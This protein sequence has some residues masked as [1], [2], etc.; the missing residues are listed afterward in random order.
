MDTTVN[1][2]PSPVRCR[3]VVVAG[4]LTGPARSLY[5]RVRGRD[6]PAGPSGQLVAA[7]VERVAMR[8]SGMLPGWRTVG[9]TR[10]W[11][12]V[13]LLST[14]CLAAAAPA[15]AAPFVYVANG[16]A[17]SVSE[18]D[19]AGG[20]LVPLPATVV[21][22]PS[23]PDLVAVAPDG[24]SV[25]VT[26]TENSTVLQFDVAANGTLTL[27]T[28]PTVQTGRVPAGI[29]VTSDGKGVYVSDFSDNRVSQYDI[30]PGGALTPTIPATV[31]TGSEPEGVA[32]SPDGKSVYVANFN[33][34]TVSQY[35]VGAGEALTP[36]TPKTVPAGNGPVGI[37]V[38]P[39]GK[40]AYVTNS[41]GNTVSQYDIGADGVLAPKTPAMVAAGNIP[42]GI[43]VSP[44][45]QSVY[46]AD[47]LDGLIAEYAVSAGG[48]VLKTPATIAAGKQPFGVVVSPDGKSVYATASLASSVFQFS[49]GSGLGTLTAK[50]PA[51]VAAGSFP[52]GIAVGPA[53]VVFRCAGVISACTVRIVRFPP[54]GVTDAVTINATSVRAA[55]LGILVERIVGKRR[56]RVGRVPFGLRHPGR[57]RIRWNLRVNGHKLAQ[58]RYVITLRMFDVHM[59]LIALARPIEITIR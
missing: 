58:G 57:L 46:V 17:N 55:G 14:A 26:D 2:P 36:K 30:G 41:A 8:S 51:N 47:S 9:G 38:S 33:D 22:G 48:L 32:V 18:Y 3:R 42:H 39:D 25:Y 13:G 37:A 28:P 21:A 27:K 34:G 24:T 49:G 35:D 43:A 10:R 4:R 12:W 53:R 52:S 59:D 11:W 45:S 29:A 19:A 40:S 54:R 6:R 7:S 15:D 44:D 20:G 5:G 1:L 23:S 16:N 56:V 31:P 50:T